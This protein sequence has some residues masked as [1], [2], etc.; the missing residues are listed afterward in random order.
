M[1]SSL[2]SSFQPSS[3]PSSSTS[4]LPSLDELL[5]RITG[6]KE[7]IKHLTQNLDRDL[8]L[9]AQMVEA[10]E[11]EPTQFWNDYTI[12]QRIRKSYDY[13][14]YIQA[15]REQLKASERLSVALGEATLKTT[16]FWEVRLPKGS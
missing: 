14:D 15:Q 7:A 13:P 3:L 1:M 12:T 16:T 6:A 10:G 5:E 4:N 11:A 2:S 9:L 8:D